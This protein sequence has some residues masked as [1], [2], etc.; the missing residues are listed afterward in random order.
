[1]QRDQHNFLFYAP[2]Q[3]ETAAELLETELRK[4]LATAI[5]LNMDGLTRLR[6]DAILHTLIDMRC[7]WRFL[8]RPALWIPCNWRDGI[9]D[10]VAARRH[11][12]SPKHSCYLP[13]PEES[14]Q[15]L[16]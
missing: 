9:Y 5:Y 7:G 16:P 8:A 3:G 1:M 10:W 15:L 14:R 11:R 2:I 12:F 6:S 4:S 13:S